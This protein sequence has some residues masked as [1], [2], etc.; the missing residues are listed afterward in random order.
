[1]ELRH[2]YLK[3]SQPKPVVVFIFSTCIL[4]LLLSYCN[5]VRL[6]Y[7]KTLRQPNTSCNVE[8]DKDYV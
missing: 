5:I 3:R 4:L 2:L 7:L 8:W 6:F 1:M